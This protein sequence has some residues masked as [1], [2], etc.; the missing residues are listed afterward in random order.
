MVGGGARLDLDKAGFD[1]A[2]QEFKT[3]LVGADVALFYYAGHAMEIRGLNYLVPVDANPT[4]EA[5]VPA[6]MTATSSIL[7]Q[8][9]KSAT[10][11]NLLLL[12]ACRDNPFGEIGRASCRERVFRAV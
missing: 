1:A 12:D 6:Q 7:D 10:R 4:G 3:Q 2:L 11:I 9:E 5:D 8:M